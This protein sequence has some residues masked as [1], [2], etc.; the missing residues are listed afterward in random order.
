[1]DFSF[2]VNTLFSEEISVV[3]S[4]LI[5]EGYSGELN[6]SLVQQQVSSI[7]D[8]MGEASSKAQ[9]LKQQI[10]SGLKFRQTEGQTAYILVDKYSNG[11]KGSVIGLLKVGH[12]TLFLLDSEGKSQ[13]MIPNCV[14]DFYVEE[15]RQR[16]GCGKK[17]FEYM[18]YKEGTHPRYMAIDRPS[19]KFISFLKKHYGL[20]NSIPQVNNYVVFS[21]FFKDRPQDCSPTPKKA[22][23]IMGKLQYV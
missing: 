6:H 15:R 16:S 5:P 9:G 14:L 20:V 2:N 17:L 1:M 12:K 19:I 18:L 8:A 13:E 21:G 4:D 23:I 3:R 22:R 11:G 7:L 10:T